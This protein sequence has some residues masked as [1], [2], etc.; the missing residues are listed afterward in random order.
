MIRAPEHPHAQKRY[1]YIAEHR[2]V[3]EKA[4]GRYLEP[5]ETVHH[6]NGDRA[7]NRLENLQLRTGKHGKGAAY[8][9]ADCGSINVVPVALKESAVPYG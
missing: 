6:I 5:Y 8:Q 7:D 4:L 9:C 1:G 3:M 2:L